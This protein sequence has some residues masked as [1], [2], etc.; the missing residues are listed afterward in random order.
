M[1][2][3]TEWVS[4]VRVRLIQGFSCHGM[5]AAPGP[6]M[7][8]QS[9][10]H[11]GPFGHLS[12]VSV[13]VT[14]GGAN[15]FDR[16]RPTY[17]HPAC[18]TTDTVTIAGADGA[19][20]FAVATFG[21]RIGVEIA[22]PELVDEALR[23][24]PPGWEA[25]EWR[26]LDRTVRLLA[27]AEPDGLRQYELHVDGR[28]EA[29]S[30]PEAATVNMLENA[31]QYHVAEFAS[32]WVFVHADVVGWRGRGM[33]IPGWSDAGTST[34]TD[35]PVDTGATCLSDECAVICPDGSV[36]PYPRP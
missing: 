14:T 7:P 22:V 23:R 9:E 4:L 8:W 10:L 26:D 28:P 33:V 13:T 6:H 32:P 19:S 35:P 1:R 5:C 31:L 36:R 2:Y 25:A 27:V 24:L 11:I 17:G 16:F 29:K 21:L 18:S 34:L 30:V 3:L 12:T 15:P 20:P